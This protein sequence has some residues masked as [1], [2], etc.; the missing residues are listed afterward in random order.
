MRV[1]PL[2]ILAT[3]LNSAVADESMVNVQILSKYHPKTVTIKTHSRIFQLN[4]ITNSDFEYHAPLDEDIEITVNNDIHRIYRGT[5]R[6]HWAGDEFTL[7]NSTPLEMY[8][9]GVVIGEIGA[10]AE[11]ELIKAQA[12]LAR[13]YALKTLKHEALFDLAYH[14]VFHGFNDYA[15]AVYPYT[16]QTKDIVLYQKNELAD[17]L[18]HA[19]CGSHIYQAGEF[20]HAANYHPPVNL[21]SGLN[22]GAQWHAILTEEQLKKVFPD[23]IQV[24]RRAGIPVMI[25]LGTQKKAVEDFRLAINRE[26]GWNTI[27]SNEFHVQPQGEGWLLS[28][29]GR[30]HLVGLCQQ[31]AEQL[32]RQGWQYGQILNLFYPFAN[33]SHSGGL[34]NTHSPL[35]YENNR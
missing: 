23:T 7:E 26:Y 15:Q 27:P 4:N 22:K 21:P 32:A 28:G 35:Y 24:I 20:W 14:Q 13:T 10:N 3:L 25:D 18:Y 33:H 19:E 34:R 11:P 1:W 8:V 17:V 9:A 12:I 5:I 16:R 2:W 30:G 31:Q 6:A 29:R